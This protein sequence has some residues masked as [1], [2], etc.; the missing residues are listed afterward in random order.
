[1]ELE[2]I[3][4]E[5]GREIPQHEYE[6]QSD[7]FCSECGSQLEENIEKI[8]CFSGKDGQLKGPFYVQDIC[9]VFWNKEINSQTEIFNL[10][11]TEW[12]PVSEWD[13]LKSAYKPP[14]PENGESKEPIIGNTNS[15]LI[16]CGACAHSFSKR[17]EK[18]P[19]CGWRPLA[20]CQVCRN[21]IPDNSISCPEC[22][23]TAP[24][25]V[26]LKKALKFQLSGR[27]T[28]LGAVLLDFLFFAI[29]LLPGLAILV[30]A[31]SD[32]N[33]GVGITLIAIG[34]LGLLIVQMYFLVSRGQSLG[35]MALGIKIVKKSDGTVPGFVKVVLLRS[36]VPS[37]LA[38]IPYAG[39]VIY[40]AD[41]LFIFRDDR[42]CIHDLIAETEVVNV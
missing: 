8:W 16:T 30:S 29:C 22:G 6:S 19:K 18:C 28:R 12:K 13:T 5:C 4:E 26:A 20:T 35:K 36:F 37:L 39:P 11:T 17:A 24:F 23:D 1:M 32:M 14:T 31:D 2:Y 33:K 38:G 40:V 3:C 25:K 7:I 10:R 41:F 9:D 27:G 21:K 15:L 34:W 42:R